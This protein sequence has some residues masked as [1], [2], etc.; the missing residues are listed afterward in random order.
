M[1]IIAALLLFLII[2][3]FICLVGLE[4]VMFKDLTDEYDKFKDDEELS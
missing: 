1:R 3:V 2:F 4:G